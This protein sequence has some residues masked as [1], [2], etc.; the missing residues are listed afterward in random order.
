ME[1]DTLFD[2]AMGI[3]RF[4]R[5]YDQFDTY[6]MPLWVKVEVVQPEIASVL[7]GDILRMK[8]YELRPRVPHWE[9][10]SE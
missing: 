10:A 5:P 8:F 1:E 7:K 9:E 4:W 6:S 2:T 3:V